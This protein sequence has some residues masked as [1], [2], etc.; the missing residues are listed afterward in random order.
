[1]LPGIRSLRGPSTPIPC[2]PLQWSFRKLTTMGTPKLSAEDVKIE[3]P[4]A[5][6]EV[7]S[8]EGCLLPSRLGGLGDRRKLPQRG[9]AEPR[10]PTRFAI[11]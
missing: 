2:P 6:S 4:K 10:S 7:G 9:P 5:L 3:A 11:F 1:M 8:G